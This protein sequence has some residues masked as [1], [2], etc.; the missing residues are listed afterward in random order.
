[1]SLPVVRSSE[2]L[3]TLVL[4]TVGRWAVEHNRVFGETMG[5]H[6]SAYVCC[7]R[8]PTSAARLGAYVRLDVSVKM[9]PVANISLCTRK[10]GGKASYLSELDCSGSLTHP[11]HKHLVPQAA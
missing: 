7:F 9:F 3:A 11:A 8:G 2:R 4:G 10:Q 6:V 1:M 5:G